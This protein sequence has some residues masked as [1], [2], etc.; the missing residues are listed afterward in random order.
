MRVLF[1]THPG[2]G[3]WHPLVPFAAALH[4]AR[5]EVAFATTPIGC[6]AISALGFRCFPVGVDDTDE[7]ARQRREE[8]AR[9]PGSEAAAWAWSNLF[10]GV[11]A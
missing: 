2:S 4:A 1:T 8:L 5:H 7:E 6:A 11:W 10:A 9:L 3:H